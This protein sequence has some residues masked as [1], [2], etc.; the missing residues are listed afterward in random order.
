MRRTQL[1]YL[2]ICLLSDSFAAGPD[3]ADFQA[4]IA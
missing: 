1:S 3:M 2:A 4:G